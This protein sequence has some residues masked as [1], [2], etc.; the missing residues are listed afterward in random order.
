MEMIIRFYFPVFSRIA[1][2]IIISFLIKIVIV[3]VG[4]WLIIWS[5]SLFILI[6]FLTSLILATL[7]LVIR[8]RRDMDSFAF[9]FRSGFNEIECRSV[10]SRFRCVTITVLVLLLLMLI[11]RST[12]AEDCLFHVF[13]NIKCVPIRLLEIEE[14]NISTIILVDSSTYLA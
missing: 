3:R 8:E 6:V 14:W 4:A 2:C 9:V 7:R 10:F 1:L 5:C 11:F 12:L 13:G